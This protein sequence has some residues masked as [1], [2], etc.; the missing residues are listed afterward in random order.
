MVFASIVFLAGCSEI[1]TNMLMDVQDVDAT[2]Q[3]NEPLL[4]KDLEG[5]CWL[6]D[7]L[8]SQI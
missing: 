2:T 7:M 5:D 1:E 6:A 3:S 8:M 4:L